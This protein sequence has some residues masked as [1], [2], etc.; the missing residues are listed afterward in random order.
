MK[1]HKNVRLPIGFIW[2]A[3]CAIFAAS[4][5]ESDT[6]AAGE[7]VAQDSILALAAADAPAGPSLVAFADEQPG[8][9]ECKTFEVVPLQMLTVDTRPVDQPGPVELTDDRPTDCA[10]YKYRDS[11]TVFLGGQGG[12]CGVDLW[13]VWPAAQF[14]H[15][16]LY[17]EDVCVERY[18]CTRCCQP[19]ASACHFFGSALLLPIQLC[20]EP[21][22]TCVATPPYCFGPRPIERSDEP[23]GASCSSGGDQSSMASARRRARYRRSL[24]V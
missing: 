24:S 10:S 23:A 4:P 9:D 14:C 2:F 13:P 15:R 20:L 17:F 19:A 16:P 18:G 6:C 1:L 7:L 11:P 8:S 12:A 5:V 22:T 21:P 3:G